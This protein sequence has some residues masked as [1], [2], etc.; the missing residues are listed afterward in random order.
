MIPDNEKL[1]YEYIRGLV[2]GEG[3]FTFCSVKRR[4][5]DIEEFRFIIPTFVI[6]MHERDTNLLIMVKNTLKLRNKINTYPPRERKDGYKRGAMSHLVVRDLGQLK[7]I[8]VPL[9]YKKLK[10]N[11]GRQFEQWL[12]KIGND[13]AV[14]DSYK[15][16]YKI[17]KAG[18]YDRNPGFE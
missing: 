15:F 12:E 7:N 13:P 16:I 17:Y 5:D 14:P 4:K 1:S 11:K 6:G 10:G 8:I 9:F 3:C 18:F 2:E